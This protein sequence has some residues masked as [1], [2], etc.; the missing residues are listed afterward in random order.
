[1]SK[2]DVEAYFNSVAEQYHEMLENIR[3]VE[4]EAQDNLTDIDLADRLKEI[5]EP[6][7]NN[8][9]TLSYIMYLL[10][11]PTRKEKQKGY[12]RR[13]KKLLSTIPQKNTKEGIL[14]ENQ[15]VIDNV[16]NI[17]KE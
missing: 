4:A 5:A 3:D 9:M 10:N 14:S 15:A 12:E 17:L 13:N 1:M 11:Q 7:K 6:L 8:F 16:A 2:K